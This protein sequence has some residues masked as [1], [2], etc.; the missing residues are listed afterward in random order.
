MRV[1]ICNIKEKKSKKK[2]GV[3]IEKLSELLKNM[4]NAI[5][6]C[7]NKTSETIDKLNKW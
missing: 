2:N 7:L 4:G 1:E 3:I 6:E 5:N